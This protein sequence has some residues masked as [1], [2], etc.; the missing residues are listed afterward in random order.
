M[1]NKKPSVGG[2]WIFPGTAHYKWVQNFCREIMMNLD[3]QKNI[4]KYVFQ[5][6]A[7]CSCH[8]LIPFFN[9]KF[10]PLNYQIPC[11]ASDEMKVIKWVQVIH[12]IHGDMPINSGL[13]I[14]FWHSLYMNT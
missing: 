6:S 7:L 9:D 12:A 8:Y 4:F 3:P 1:P 11:H 10:C 13:H 2:V 5:D 14:S